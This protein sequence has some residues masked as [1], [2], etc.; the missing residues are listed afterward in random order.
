MDRLLFHAIIY[1]YIYIYINIIICHTRYMFSDCQSSGI[2]YVLSRGWE[3][4]TDR[5]V[6][7][8]WMLN[9]WEENTLNIQFVSRDG[10]V[11]SK[12]QFI[13]YCLYTRSA[14]LNLLC[15]IWWQSYLLD[16]ILGTK[17]SRTVIRGRE[18]EQRQLEC[19]VGRA[20]T[21]LGGEQ[22]LNVIP[23]GKKC[24]ALVILEALGNIIFFNSCIDSPFCTKQGGLCRY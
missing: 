11:N 19:Q 23:D 6:C 16:L 17:V 24:S 2:L 5:F 9:C 15:D 21:V 4:S 20:S 13:L 12:R 3:I 1:I 7:Y 18:T 14:Y 8:V 22:Q 10:P